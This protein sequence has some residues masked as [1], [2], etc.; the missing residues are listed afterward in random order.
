M[1]ASQENKLRRRLGKQAI[2]FAGVL[3]LNPR[4]SKG[5]PQTEPSVVRI[6]GLVAANGGASAGSLVLAATLCVGAEELM[7]L[8]HS[9][10]RPS[11]ETVP[12]GVN[13]NGSMACFKRVEMLCGGISSANHWLDLPFR[14]SFRLDGFTI[15]AIWVPGSLGSKPGRKR[16]TPLASCQWTRDWLQE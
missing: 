9:W 8:A 3:E 6:L 2:A 14:P 12:Q 5:L 1:E 11:A 4:H 7:T 13:G 16:E 10:D 15:L